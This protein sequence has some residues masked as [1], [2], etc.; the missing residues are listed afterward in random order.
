MLTLIETE[1]NNKSFL[2][3]ASM[4][5]GDLLQISVDIASI[6]AM[7]GDLWNYANR[8]SENHLSVLAILES[9]LLSLVQN[10]TGMAQQEKLDAIRE[11]L[12]LLRQSTLTDPDVESIRSAFIEAGFSP[13]AFLEQIDG[14][15]DGE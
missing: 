1:V 6:T 12:G 13:L 3:A 10:S 14:S 5:S 7:T 15:G 9:G 8:V 11:A 2:E 4:E